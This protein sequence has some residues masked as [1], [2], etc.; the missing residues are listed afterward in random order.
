LNPI[1]NIVVPTDFSAS[2]RAA[3]ARA[4]V[5]ARPDGAAIHLVHAISVPKLFVPYEVSVPGAVWEAV[6]QA[7]EERL[8]EARK[9][10]EADGIA[11]VTGSVVDVSDVTKAIREAV[12]ANHADLVV[13]GTQGQGKVR[14]AFFGSTAA[15]A[16]RSIYCPVIVVK[17]P[18]KAAAEAIR[19]I[20]VA[21]DSSADSDR[22][23]D[24][25]TALA[26]RLDAAVDLVHAIEMPRA[27]LPSVYASAL[28][29]E[30]E[31]RMRDCGSEL[32]EGA[33]RQVADGGLVATLHGRPGQP[34]EVI[35]EVAKEIGCQLI[36]MGTRG[37]TGVSRLL[38]GSVAERTLRAA[39]CS[40]MTVTSKLPRDPD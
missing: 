8:E 29:V 26:G 39:P 4:A 12:D 5:L 22:A 10:L 3:M 21:V 19:R 14:K 7:A 2:A 11:S 30:I 20:L 34:P 31:Q 17:E 38:I 25:A 35:A 1:R 33:K 24:A 40:V 32:L 13:M 27:F 16:V 36:V 18:A 28:G 9:N 15:D 37:N 6:Q 23:V